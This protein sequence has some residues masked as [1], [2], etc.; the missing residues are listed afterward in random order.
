MKE[1]KKEYG[2]GIPTITLYHYSGT[3]RDI[4]MFAENGT[5]VWKK[6][7]TSEGATAPAVVVSNER[8]LTVRATANGAA[9]IPSFAGSFKTIL[10]IK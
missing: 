6:N 7:V 3:G 8:R 10:E 5:P 4:I 9:S 1:A 2:P